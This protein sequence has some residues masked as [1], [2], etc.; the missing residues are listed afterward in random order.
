MTTAKTAPMKSCNPAA[1]FECFQDRATANHGFTIQ[2]RDENDVP[3]K[4]QYV[5]L[6]IHGLSDSPY[7][8]RDISQII[9]DHGINVVAIRTTGHGTHKNHLKKVNRKD[10]YK[11]VEYGIKLA[12]NYGEKVIIA[13]MSNGGA[14]ALREAQINPAVKGLMLF[15]GAI[16]MPKEMNYSCLLVNPIT[17]LPIKVLG[18]FFTDTKT[19]Q[20]RKEYG[21]D[22]RYQGI[23]NNG[24]CQLTKINKE[25]HKRAKKRSKKALFRDINIPVFNVVS[26]YDDVLVKDYMM[27]F[28]TN[29][30]SNK[31]GKSFLVLYQDQSKDYEWN[32]PQRVYVQKVP[33]MNHASVLL[34][35][36][37]EMNYTDENQETCKYSSEQVLQ[38]NTEEKLDFTPEVNFHFEL[39]EMALNDFLSEN[40]I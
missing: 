15:S 22:V 31:N 20:A 27:N 14:L 24:T 19:Y 32:L 34:R 5:A 37:V 18:S 33:C 3:I 30:A 26:E 10:W 29:V 2:K 7:F 39:M 36:S 9:F 35:A 4:T 6:L 21:L 11:D 25:T 8:Y 40:F 17:K 1:I 38:F 12:K 28:S 23:H 13:G 16:K